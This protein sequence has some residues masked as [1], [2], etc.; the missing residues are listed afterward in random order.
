MISKLKKILSL[1][2]KSKDSRTLLENFISLSLLQVAGYVFPLLTAPYLV[3]TIGVVKYGEIAFAMAV[4]IYFQTVVDY[5]FIFSGVRDVARCRDNTCDVSRI[6]SKVMWSRWLLVIVSFSLLLLLIVL[7]PYFSNMRAVLLISFLTVVGHAMFPDWMFQAIEKMKYITVFNVL[8]KLL[9]T[10]CVF[11]FIHKPEDY[12]LQPLFT[13]LGY[14]IAGCG[15]MFIIHRW[16]YH[17]K[18]PSFS[19]IRRSLKDNFDLFINQLVPNLYNSTSVLFLGFFHGNAANGIYDA[20]NRFNTVG[21]SFFS[22]ISRTF[23]PFLSRRIDKHTF[24]ARL[25]LILSASIGVFLF[26]TAPWIIYTFFPAD[27]DS[28]IIVLRILSV[29]LVFL[30]MNNIY[31]TNYLILKG[32]EKKMRSITLYSSLLGLC[33]GIPCVYWFSYIGVALTVTFSRCLMGVW[34][35]LVAVR[36][37]HLESDS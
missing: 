36:L 32:H 16:G 33:V 23:Y 19:E 4:M 28:A 31:G 35:M 22:I 9:F 20:A 27:F 13:S 3:H 5:G 2:F 24:F 18:R 14:I 6:Y 17:L 34:S 29:G 1:K 12:L 25:N 10:L 21:S 7:V 15:A 37:Q 30:A 26:L 8:V 11:M